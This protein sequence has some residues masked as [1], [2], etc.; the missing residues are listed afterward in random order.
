MDNTYDKPFTEGMSQSIIIS[1]TIS[2]ARKTSSNCSNLGIASAY[3]RLTQGL[4]AKTSISA[5]KYLD[6]PG[7]IILNR[8]ENFGP[9]FYRTALS[10]NTLYLYF[11]FG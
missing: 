7:Q 5:S 2:V 9:P 6:S 4:D 1:T 8:D 11:A 10:K 3:L